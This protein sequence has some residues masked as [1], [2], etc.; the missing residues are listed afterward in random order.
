MLLATMWKDK[1]K[2]TILN[3]V[4]PEIGAKGAERIR[5]YV[6]QARNFDTW[7][8]AARDHCRGTW[9]SLSRLYTRRLAAARQ[10]H[11]Q[12]TANGRIVFDYDMKI[13][14][15]FKQP[16]GEAGLTCGRPLRRWPTSR[17]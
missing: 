7:M 9:R 14:E 11:L 1:M 2:G 15:P 8:H 12:A 6:G 5:G 16:G 10:A 3:D 17:C 13:A 4:G